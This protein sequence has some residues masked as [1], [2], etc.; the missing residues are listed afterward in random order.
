MKT[1]IITTEKDFTG[2]KDAWN[3]L[4]EQ[5]PHKSIFLTWEWMHTWWTSYRQKLTDPRLHIVTFYRQNE[6]AAILPLFSHLRKESLGRL[7]CLQFLGTEFE[8]S[9][10][11]DIIQAGDVNETELRQALAGAEFRE[12]LRS[13]DMLILANAFADA[14][15]APLFATLLTGHPSE[16]RRT[17]V[18]PYLPLP[19]S[20]EELFKQLSKNMKSTLRRT[21]NKI[22]KDPDFRIG[23]VEQSEDIPAAVDGL[24]RLHALRFDDKNQSTKFVAG[25]RG[26]FHKRI[27]ALWL[28]MKRLRFYTITHKQQPIG[29]L[30][31]YYH[32]HKILYMQAGFHPD[33]GKYGLGNQL[34]LRAMNDGMAGG[35]DEFDFMRGNE[36]YKYK[37]TSLFRELYTTRY[38]LTGKAAR[39]LRLEAALGKAKSLVKKLLPAR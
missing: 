20:E 26:D 16:S 36:S 18:C 23:L 4:E 9:D 35:A 22:N 2:L 12:L 33:Y 3:T 24:F 5:S 6:L 15:M 11:L 14:R 17:S 27:A 37:W 29:F 31:C 8:S 10:Y 19:A 34:M 28:E 21:R 25:H 1:E 32:N 39:H 30:Y 13:A 7:R 38:A